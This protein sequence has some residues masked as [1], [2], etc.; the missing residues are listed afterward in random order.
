MS[1]YLFIAILCATMSSVYRPLVGKGKKINGSCYG[2]G[3]GKAK[4]TAE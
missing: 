4:S 2:Y 3:N 1:F